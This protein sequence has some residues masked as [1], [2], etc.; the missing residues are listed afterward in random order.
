MIEDLIHIAKKTKEVINRQR[1]LLQCEADRLSHPYAPVAAINMYPA[2]GAWGGSSV[3]VHQLISAL[4]QCGIRSVFSLRSEVDLIFLIDPRDDL[5]N[6]AFGMKEIQ[7]YRRQNP[8][9]RIIHRINEC[10][11]RKGTRFIDE[12]LREANEF[13]DYTIFISEWLRDYFAGQWFDTKCPH[14]VIYNGADPKIFHPI[15]NKSF[16]SFASLRIVTH[17]WS[18]HPMKG[19]S[20]Y[21]QLDELIADGILD[22]TELW[23]I[24]RWPENL[25]WRSARTF[26]PASG[27]RLAALLRKCHVYLTASRWEPCGMHHIE[28]AQCGLPLLYHEDG[29]GIVEAGHSYGICFREDTLLKAVEEMRFRYSELRSQ[30]FAAMPSGIRMADEYVRTVYPLL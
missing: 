3:F 12:A 7:Q 21:K 29:G 30:L 22:A 9:V 19:F 24:G 28:G 14:K 2:F 11:Q 23:I 6:K 4:R 8:K 20:V 26:P 1:M 15:G 5:L 16:S 13:A 25:S 18:D 27:K 10:D 17:H